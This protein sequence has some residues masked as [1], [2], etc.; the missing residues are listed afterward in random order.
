MSREVLMRALSPFAVGECERK[1]E[2]RLITKLDLYLDGLSG[3]DGAKEKREALALR[4]GLPHDMTA[5]ALL[6]AI[7]IL[8]SYEQYKEWVGQL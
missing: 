8:Y 3:R 1:E 7:N 4:L 5:D 6:E 2:K